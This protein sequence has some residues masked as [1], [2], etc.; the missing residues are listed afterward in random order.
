MP[1]LICP[2]C[3]SEFYRPLKYITKALTQPTCSMVC[4]SEFERLEAA[5]IT[6]KVCSKCEEDKPLGDFYNQHKK[7]DGK[8][9]ACKKCTRK[10]INQHHEENPE[11]RKTNSKT[12]FEKNKGK[13]LARQ[14]QYYQENRENF[15]EKVYKHRKENPDKIKEQKRKHYQGHKQEIIQKVKQYRLDNLETVKARQKE[16]RQ[17]PETRIKIRTRN[18]LRSTKQKDLPNT[19]TMSNWEYALTYW[20]GCCAVCGRPPGLWHTLAMDHW[21]PLANPDC[22]GTVPTN[23]IPLCHGVDGCNNNKKDKDPNIWLVQKYGP[24][25][26]KAKLKEIETYFAILLTSQ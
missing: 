5:K 19:L 20:K 15:L 6:H 13:I 25:K 16:S 21:I 9:A 22:P 8:S 18:R 4:R 2:V 11:N 26:A 24:K 14:N 12:Y 17:E 10:Q 23:I 1:D 7:F 3:D